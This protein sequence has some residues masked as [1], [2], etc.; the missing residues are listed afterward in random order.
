MD[1]GQWVMA[2]VFA[3]LAWLAVRRYR[4]GRRKNVESEVINVRF[5]VTSEGGAPTP[6]KGAYFVAPDD[7]GQQQWSGVD[8]GPFAIK[9]L[10]VAQDMCLSDAADQGARLAP[11]PSGGF[12]LV[13]SR[14]APH[15]TRTVTTLAKHGL[16]APDGDGYVITDKGLQA[17]E[18]LRMR[19]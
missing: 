13:G 10:T 19:S 5:S 9:S 16:L 15:P 14:Y 12:A 4:R 8:R 3:W 6:A 7:V 18:T 11:H 1:V 17:R 2:A